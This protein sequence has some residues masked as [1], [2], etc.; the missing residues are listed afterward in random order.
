MNITSKSRTWA[1]SGFVTVEIENIECF[2]GKGKWWGKLLTLP[3]V[4]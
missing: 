2:K 4:C 1:E 3:A